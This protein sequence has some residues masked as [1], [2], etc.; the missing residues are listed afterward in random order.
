M[1]GGRG[2]GVRGKGR[3]G[4]G[5]GG[6]GGS[7]EGRRKGIGMAKGEAYLV[8]LSLVSWKNRIPSASP[9]TIKSFFQAT[10]MGLFR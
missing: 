1:G 6:G 3:G 7:E 10:H 5:R 8:W 4:G 9:A 2:R